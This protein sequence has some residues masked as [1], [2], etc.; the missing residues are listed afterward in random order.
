M[1][2]KTTK[3]KKKKWFTILA[4]KEF[5]HQNIGETPCYTEQ[6]LVG[7][8]L[9]I[10]LM[11]LLN[12]S[13]K[14]NIRILFKIKE[15]K[16]GNANTDLIGYKILGSYIKRI[17]RK[18]VK[19][20]ENSFI[21]ETKDKDKIVIKTVFITKGKPNKAVLKNLRDT[22]KE[23]L[24][25]Q[26]KNH[27]FNNIILDVIHSKLQKSLRTKLNK[28]YPLIMCELRIVNKI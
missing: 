16:D 27:D 26:A 3:G 14:Q 20:V 7:R 4:S 13:K 25:E 9:E 11:N 5:K 23:F 19:K 8:K 15:I 1:A 24:I 10:N 22:S 18:N 2:R 17:L 28:I 6:E 12:D 21:T